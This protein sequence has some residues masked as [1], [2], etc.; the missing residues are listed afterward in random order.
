MS[1]LDSCEVDCDR[2]NWL[3]KKVE[4][5]IVPIAVIHDDFEAMRNIVIQ[6]SNL[7]HQVGKFVSSF[8]PL[9]LLCSFTSIVYLTLPRIFEQFLF[10]LSIVVAKNKHS[11]RWDHLFRSIS[12]TLSSFASNSFW[13]W[14]PIIP[15]TTETVPSSRLLR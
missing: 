11:S 8:V 13:R 3:Q 14:V 4:L 5:C 7:A 2:Y 9:A 15:A 1:L 10:F 12:T 6:S